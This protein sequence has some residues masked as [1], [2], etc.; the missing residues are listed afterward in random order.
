MSELLR[1]DSL[2]V[3]YGRAEVLKGLSLELR[4]GRIFGLVGESGCGKTTLLRAVMGLLESGGRISG[5]RV[6]FEG[7]DL[8]TVSAEEMRRLRGSR[9]SLMFQNPGES[10]NPTRTIG[11]QFLETMRSHG[12]FSANEAMENISGMLQCLD[13]K[14]PE[15][16]LKSYP[17]ELSGGMLQRAAL[18][19]AMILKPD[20]LLADEPTSALDAIVQAQAVKEMMKLRDEFGTAIVVISHSMGVVARM[21]DQ[22]GVMYAGRLVE[23]GDTGAVLSKPLHPY[24]RALMAAVPRLDGRWPSATDG[25]PPPPEHNVRG[26]GFAGRCQLC[27]AEC[28]DRSQVLEPVEAGHLVA[29]LR[30]GC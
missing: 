14:E 18:A 6:L 13:L 11:R 17:Y 2:R 30:A 1:I 5:G 28:L 24:T 7:R 26:C 25:A 12:S 29:C 23:Y 15:R 8:S 4:P 19:L 27:A 3:N 16:I 9:M 10:F 22:V 21:A 20:L